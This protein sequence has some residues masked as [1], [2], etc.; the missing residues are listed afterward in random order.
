[1]KYI[2]N[3]ISDIFA[4][5]TFGKQTKR[6][7]IFLLLGV[8]AGCGE[9]SFVTS[10]DNAQQKGGDVTVPISDEPVVQSIFLST[11]SPSMGSAESDS[12]SISARVKNSNNVAMENV[13]I[14]FAANGGI[15]DVQAAK[16]DTN[17]IATA[18]L[19]AFGDPRNRTITVTAT[20]VG[21][22]AQT[23][24]V[25]IEVSGTTVSV[26]GASSLVF[27]ASTLIT[28][29]V[30]NS[31]GVGL[32]DQFVT[33]T[34]RK[35]NQ[36][37]ETTLTTG[38][39]GNDQFTVTA[40]V[41]G[42]DVITV[43]SL[44]AT[45]ELALNVSSDEFSFVTPV[46]DE[47]NL[48]LSHDI[49]VL[50]SRAG[51]LVNGEVVHFSTTRGTLSSSS[52]TTVNGL[53]SLSISSRNAGPTV[54]TARTDGGA[55]TSISKEFFATLPE[56]LS[57]QAN[58]TN[59][60]PNGEESAL[61]AIVRD[62][63]SNL[64]KNAIINFSILEDS[65]G[66]GISNDIGVSNSQGRA[67]SI[68]TSTTATTA[69]DGIII[70]AKLQ[71]V[72]CAIQTNLCDTIALGVTKKALFVV[73]GTGNKI[74]I[75]SPTQYR[76]PYTALVTDAAGVA[77]PNAVVEVSLVPTSYRTGYLTY[78][79]GAGTNKKVIVDVCP[80]EDRNLDGEIGLRADNGL[81]ED[82]NGNGD[83]DPRNV[84]SVSG[85]VVTGSD[86]FANIDIIYAKEFAIW[87]GVKLTAT[88]GR[89]QGTESSD[90]VP[91]NLFAETG[92]L[93]SKDNPPSFRSP[94][95]ATSSC[96]LQQFF[97]PY[98][99]S[100]TPSSTNEGQIRISWLDL[101]EAVSYNLYKVTP[102][103]TTIITDVVSPYLDVGLTVDTVYT[104]YV[105][106]IFVPGLLDPNTPALVEGSASR[107]VTASA[108][109]APPINVMLPLP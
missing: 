73:L 75:H 67:S 7:I 78:D 98:G 58:N 88:V 84:A 89:V 20:V 51:N 87:V 61:T 100:A 85:S 74:F 97:V 19:S 22:N 55:T 41:A 15:L 57:L 59:I 43:T 92:E 72:D 66:G 105:T 63:N 29:F 99:V 53:A 65:S 107:Q 79:A 1:M 49:S 10:D 56:F 90:S 103:G 12:V 27:G 4:T 11:S 102:A 18:K 80:N 101:P 23:S 69:P 42:S 44:G 35:G 81:S 38:I 50:W 26:S 86:G 71:G 2:I 70:Q 39:N 94:W 16:T 95:G 24:N 8:L 3:G 14:I 96:S 13:D 17:G 9:D 104:Y 46:L 40:T 34:S 21:T 62:G 32:K 33:V 45:A 47:L 36:V 25:D 93:N 52:V 54:I 108:P 76:Y 30:R 64:V 68:Y 31:D 60:G 91:F 109:A 48:E 82:T 6:I 5:Q 28:V 83:L 77:V 37:S 106:G